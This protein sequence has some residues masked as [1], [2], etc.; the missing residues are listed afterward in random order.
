MSWNATKGGENLF[1]RFT[2][3]IKV[4]RIRAQIELLRPLQRASLRESHLFEDTRFEPGG[5]HTMTDQR[6]EVQNSS[7]AVSITEKQLKTRLR[8]DFQDSHVIASL[9]LTRR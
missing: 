3:E 6:R 2:C 9:A 1:G 4:K 5:K 8:R 7:D